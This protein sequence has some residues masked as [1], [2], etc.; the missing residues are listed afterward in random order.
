ME[1]VEDIRKQNEIINRIN[2][3]GLLNINVEKVEKVSNYRILTIN[4]GFNGRGHWMVY[5]HQ[6]R[7]IIASFLDAW[8]IELNVDN[9]DDVWTLKLGVIG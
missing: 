7:Q 6:I 9:L 1:N 3:L 4:G 8:I 5:L 2:A